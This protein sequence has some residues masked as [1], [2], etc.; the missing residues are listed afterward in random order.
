MA[1][2]FQELAFHALHKLLLRSG[3]VL[4]GPAADRRT[5]HPGRTPADLVGQH[6]GS[7][8]PA[9][10]PPGPTPAGVRVLVL[11]FVLWLQERRA[12]PSAGRR[13]AQPPGPWLHLHLQTPADPGL[14]Q[15]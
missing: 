2:S 7:M 8:A 13:A 15:N 3:R 10:A 5:R 14:G 4:V 11:G 12:A 9:T 1:V 6:A